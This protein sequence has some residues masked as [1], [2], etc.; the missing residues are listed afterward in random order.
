M[1]IVLRQRTVPPT[2]ILQ[3]MFERTKVNTKQNIYSPYI[4]RKNKNTDTKSTEGHIHGLPYQ[5]QNRW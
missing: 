4:G 1:L 2:T 5:T 3:Q